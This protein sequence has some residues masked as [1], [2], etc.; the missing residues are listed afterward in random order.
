MRVLNENNVYEEK[1]NLAIYNACL[2]GTYQDAELN[3]YYLRLLY[4]IVTYYNYHYMGNSEKITFIG[5]FITALRELNKK[6]VS[7]FELADV[8][9]FLCASSV[10]ARNLVRFMEPLVVP[11]DIDDTYLKRFHEVYH[12]SFINKEF[13]G[14]D[15]YDSFMVNMYI[16]AQECIDLYK[17]KHNIY[18][19]I[20]E[21]YKHVNDDNHLAFYEDLVFNVISYLGRNRIYQY[22]TRSIFTYIM[23]HEDELLVYCDLNFTSN[24]K[25]DPPLR[26]QFDNHLVEKIIN[27]WTNTIEK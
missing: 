7:F 24:M 16:I 8:L 3:K 11:Q 22:D 21:D 27:D 4:A 14:D 5:D 17:E 19:S 15:K 23:D 12:L 13:L 10:Q 18:T 9:K 1:D 20:Y 2:S 26:Y 25:N 6:N